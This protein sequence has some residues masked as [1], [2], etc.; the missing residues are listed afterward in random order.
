M[1]YN[2][3]RG[4]SQN[5]VVNDTFVLTEESRQ[6]F[7]TY[8]ESCI[9]RFDFAT[10]R[11]TYLKIDK[12]I[13]LESDTRRNLGKNRDQ[14]LDYYD[15][16]EMSHIS[17]AVG[18]VKGFLVDL[19]LASPNI[20]PAVPDTASEITL[21]KQ[22]DAITMR[23][24]TDYCWA[25]HLTMAF[26]D[27][28]KYNKVVLEVDWDVQPQL[29]ISRDYSTGSTSKPEVVET[30]KSGNKI[31]RHSVYNAFHDTVV[32]PSE[33]HRYG[34]YAGYT[35]KISMVEL[36]RRIRAMKAQ[37]K[38]VMSYAECFKAS[39]TTSNDLYF[40]PVVVPEAPTNKDSGWNQG[41]WKHF[42]ELDEKSGDIFAR[43]N[44]R[45]PPPNTEYLWTV[46]YA[47]IIPSMF[48]ITEVNYKNKVQI[49]RIVR[50]GNTLISVERMKNVHNY[51]N[52]LVAQVKEEGI[53]EQVKSDAALVIPFQNLATKLYDARM[54]SLANSVGN[55]M[56]YLEGAVDP[57]D[58]YHPTRAVSV[59]PNMFVKDVGAA[60]RQ[61]NF[62][63]TMGATF[64]QEINILKANSQE[65][66]GL[67]RA[68][69]GQ[70]QKGNKTAAE[71]NE[72]MINAD[73]DLRTFGL[74]VENT[75]MAPIKDM[76]RS[77]IAQFQ[78][79]EEIV[80]QSNEEVTV[81]PL[82]LSTKVINFKLADGL[83]RKEGLTNP[84]ALW[85]AYNG[86]L[87]NPQQAAQFDMAG[88]YVYIMEMMGAKISQFKLRPQQGAPA[89]APVAQPG[90]APAQQQPPQPPAV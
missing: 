17:Q 56:A 76:L 48:G 30:L 69:M 54:R 71:F 29:V 19:F 50:V 16:V 83:V 87:A 72:V 62:Q 31:T 40:E 4:R 7:N 24:S 26:G 75:I 10:R 35:E 47:R 55:K 73:S 64:H 61:L 78:E 44:M 20:F 9:S 3:K 28:A 18:T 85:N 68:Q 5:K 77:N 81:N 45:V 38:A 58:L 8:I 70:F 66:T 79:A 6:L 15:D 14:R 22:L 53:K 32:E 82:D 52:I 11:N 39:T 49:F 21:A 90:Q 80:S 36:V 33:V 65:V 89:A 84:E 34:E 63:D 12:A 25:R 41:S 23:D 13:Q 2:K 51:L 46:T 1:S 86:M 27:L 43:N 88:M 37:N 67:N 59:K 74:L 57:A 60:V 42:F